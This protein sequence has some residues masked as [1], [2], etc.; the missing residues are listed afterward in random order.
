MDGVKGKALQVT[1]A[2]ISCQLDGKGGM[3][4]IDETQVTA[5][6]ASLLVAS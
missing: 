2:I 6:R 1:D 5:R 4:P 3:I